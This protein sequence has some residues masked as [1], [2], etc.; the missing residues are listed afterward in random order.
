LAFQT[1]RSAT[2]VDFIGTDEVDVLVAFNETGLV[3]VTGQQADD[4][5]TFNSIISGVITTTT[6]FAGQGDDFIDII[7]AF[8]DSLI[9]GNQGDDTINLGLVSNST[10]NGGQGNDS[11]VVFNDVLNSLISADDGNDAV[12]VF[13]NTF[14]SSTVN[15]NVGNDVITLA[16]GGPNLLAGSGVFG[17]KDN[18]TINILPTTFTQ[19]TVNGNKGNDVIT[20]NTVQG[21]GIFVFGGQD[22]DTINYFAGDSATLSGDL[23]DDSITATTGD[24]TILGGDGNDTVVAGTGIDSILGGVGND[25]LDGGGG[26]DLIFGGDGNDVIAGGDGAIDQIT[27]GLGADRYNASVSTCEYIINAVAESAAVTSGTT[28]TFD[29]FTAGNSFVTGT[30]SLDISAVASSLAGGA[31]T[32]VNPFVTLG[33]IAAADFGA[34]KTALDALAGATVFGSTVLGIQGYTFSI[35]AGDI[36]GRYLWIQDNQNTFTSTDLLFQTG[37]IN[38]IT[39]G[40]VLV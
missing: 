14:A 9:N 1:V 35:A 22:Q 7:D 18:D 30:D 2:G 37:T 28:R 3:T 4:S 17:G 6:I 38:Q 25:S 40:D 31:V 11:F 24:N 29:L 5:I 21:T 8:T 13:F 12:D 33:P 27:G 19:T 39:S 23:G 16:G 15:G 20:L 26:S 36:A 34:L 10:I 32:T